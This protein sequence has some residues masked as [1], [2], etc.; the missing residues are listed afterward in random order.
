MT[1][2]VTRAGVPPRAQEGVERPLRAAVDTAATAIEST[3]LDRVATLVVTVVPVGL[4]GLAAWLAWGG[5]LAVMNCCFYVAIS[6]QPLATVAA[7]EFLPVEQTPVDHNS[8]YFA[9]I[10]NVCKGVGIQ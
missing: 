9:H 7:I 4:I 5:V 6:R 2:D 3:A 8:R 10:L 1:L